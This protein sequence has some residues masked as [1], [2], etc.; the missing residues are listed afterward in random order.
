MSKTP[1][2]K[3]MMM[4]MMMMMMVNMRTMTTKKEEELESQRNMSAS[5]TSNTAPRSQNPTPHRTHRLTAHLL[6]LPY[7]R[8]CA[9]QYVGKSQSCM[10]ISGRLIVHAPEQDAQ[11]LPPPASSARSGETV[12]PVR[13]RFHIIGSA[14]IEN[15]GKSQSCMVSKIRMLWQQTAH[16][17]LLLP[18]LLR[19][20]PPLPRN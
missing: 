11:P 18:L 7:H 8:P 20:L 19:V 16:L 3:M 14:R 9:Q 4:M 6:L 12:N 17:L 13:V 15:V 2:T 10:V 5:S 1:T